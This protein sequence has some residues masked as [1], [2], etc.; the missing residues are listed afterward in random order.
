[1]DALAVNRSSLAAFSF[2]PQRRGVWRGDETDPQLQR[3]YGTG[4]PPRRSSGGLRSSCRRGALKRDHPETGRRLELFLLPGRLGQSV[5]PVWHP[6]RWCRAPGR[7]RSLQPEDP[8]RTRL[9]RAPCTRRHVAKADLWAHLRPPR[10]LC[11]RHPYPGMEMDEGTEYR[12]RADELPVLS[13]FCF[14]PPTRVR[15]SAGNTLPKVGCLR[16]ARVQGWQTQ[17]G[18]TSQPVEQILAE[19]ALLNRVFKV[20]MGSSD[21][22]YITGLD[23]L[24]SSD[25][26]AISTC[27]SVIWRWG[28][29]LSYFFG[30]HQPIRGHPCTH[31]HCYPSGL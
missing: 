23:G 19:Q 3:I 4:K 27:N 16:D 21:D 12:L 18:W 5:S 22:A 30:G 13:C 10:F 2:A 20:L 28:F 14:P 29:F 8:C 6:R 9:V 31:H 7:S 1:M 25:T 15:S 17:N 11:G 24:M 26:D